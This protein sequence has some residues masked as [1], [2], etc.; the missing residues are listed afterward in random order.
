MLPNIKWRVPII[1]ASAFLGVCVGLYQIWLF[2]SIFWCCF[3]A[4]QRNEHMSTKIFATASI[5]WEKGCIFW[6]NCKGA[7]IFGYECNTIWDTALFLTIPCTVLH[8]HQWVWTL[9]FWVEKKVSC[10]AIGSPVH[11]AVSTAKISCLFKSIFIMFLR[12]F[13][14]L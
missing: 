4:N 14:W 3:N 6:H 7:N 12:C 9:S 11:F 2:F 5:F 8:S 10:M 13:S 1:L